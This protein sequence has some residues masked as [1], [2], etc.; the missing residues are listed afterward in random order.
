MAIG[1]DGRENGVGLILNDEMKKGVLSD[2]RRL[3]VIIWVKVTLNGELINNISAY[4]P[5]TG[6]G[7]NEKIKLWEE[8]D[9]ELR[10][11]PDTEKLWVGGD[12]NGHWEGITVE[13]NKPLE[14]M[15]WVIAMKMETI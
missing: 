7:K 2:K 12:F 14:T 1:E 15:V 6:C 4:A 3:D 13:M 11:I 5:Q 9:E 10:D 8:M